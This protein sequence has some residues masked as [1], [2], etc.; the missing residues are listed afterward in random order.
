M[1]GSSYGLKT[2]RLNFT[3]KSTD[4][5]NPI[6][7]YIVS[8]S[9]YLF[10]N[11]GK[12]TR[13]REI[14]SRLDPRAVDIHF[15][16]MRWW[17]GKSPKRNGMTLHSICPQ[18]TMYRNGKRSVGQALLF[19]ICCARLLSFPR[20]DVL[21]GDQMPLLHLFPLRIITGFWR[22]PFVCTWHEVWGPVAWRDYLGSFFGTL[23]WWVEK[24]ALSL[25][26]RFIAA[27][28]EVANRLR[29]HGIS[30]ARIYGIP[31]GIDLVPARDDSQIDSGLIVSIGRLI[32]HK[33]FDVAIAA[34]AILRSRGND[35]RLQIIGE[36]P[37]RSSLAELARTLGVEDVVTI[38]NDISAETTVDTFRR[39]AQLFL[40]PSDREGF[41]IAV[42]EALACGVPVVT[43][44]HV[45]NFARSLVIHGETGFIADSRD[46]ASFAWAIDKA[47]R[48]G[49]DA[50]ETRRIFLEKNHNL[51]WDTAAK[52]YAAA[53]IEA[54][55]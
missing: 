23:A 13:H 12:E 41:G 19:G 6:K 39:K 53:L 25:P 30:D 16:T 46:P 33:N 55:S 2:R 9:H 8:D 35:Y 44:D 26:D 45:D 27:S 31:P 43:S 15:F 3:R 50:T 32:G 20:P 49:F 51:S 5:H 40:A 37:V 29:A 36:G 11:G 21:E 54:R 17:A 34:L 48:R 28:P 10:M 18:L 52:S 4:V 24:F 7:L 42:A 38:S 22:V 14:L 47:M 1:V